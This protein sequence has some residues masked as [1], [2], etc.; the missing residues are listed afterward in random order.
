MHR[1]IPST[2]FS[3]S[4]AQRAVGRLGIRCKIIDSM[5]RFEVSIS[6]GPERGLLSGQ[7]QAVPNDLAEKQKYV[8]LSHASRLTVFTVLALCAA[9]FLWF[10]KKDDSNED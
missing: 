7:V 9:L 8:V 1:C 6:T 3:S 5:T 4:R 2:G 10:F